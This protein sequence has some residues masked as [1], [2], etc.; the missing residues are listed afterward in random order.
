MVESITQLA[1]MDAEETLALAASPN[2]PDPRHMDEVRALGERIGYGNL[3]TTASA[4][5]G[6]KMEAAGIGGS[7]FVAGPCRS[8]VEKALALVRSAIKE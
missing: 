5:W 7:E 4:I 3:M 2:I 8:T 6:E 1:L